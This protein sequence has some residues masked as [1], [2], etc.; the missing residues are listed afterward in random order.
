MK[1]GN[2]LRAIQQF[3]RANALKIKQT[4]KIKGLS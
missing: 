2:S 4:Q 1:W 3:F